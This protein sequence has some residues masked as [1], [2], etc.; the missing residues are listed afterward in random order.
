MSIHPANVREYSSGHPRTSVI[1]RRNG[2]V[3]IQTSKRLS[4][5]ENLAVAL[6]APGIEN[7]SAGSFFGATSIEGV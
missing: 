1:K 7:S 5:E 3:N 2:N 6:N 4:N